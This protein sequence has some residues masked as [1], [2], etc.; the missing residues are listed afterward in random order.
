MT[1]KLDPNGLGLAAPNK[2]MT[3]SNATGGSKL[4]RERREEQPALGGDLASNEED[5]VERRE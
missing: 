1:V 5:R 4:R 2:D 3:L